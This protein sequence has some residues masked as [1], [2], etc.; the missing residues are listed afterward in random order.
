MTLE[1]TNPQL[2]NHRTH[3]HEYSGLQISCLVVLGDGC[4]RSNPKTCTNSIFYLTLRK[5]VYQLLVAGTQTCTCFRK[6]AG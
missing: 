5:H 3:M 2:C 6:R 4:L 1:T